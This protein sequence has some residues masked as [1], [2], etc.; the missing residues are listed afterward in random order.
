MAVS[1]DERVVEM[2]FNNKQFEEGVRQS[3][4]SLDN[5]DQSIDNLD[6]KSLNNL[7]ERLNK[8]NFDAL[9]RGMDSLEKRFSAFGV[10]GMT[11]IQDLVHG[12]EGLGAKLLSV[13]TKPLNIMKEGGWARA[14]NIE[15]AKFQIE[16]LGLSFEQLESSI[17]KA[18][19]GT[20]YGF[21]A[22]AKAAGQ[23]SAS[24]VKAGKD[25]DDAL[26]AI[27]GVAA[28]T[29]KSYEEISPIF[30]AVAGQ[31]KA[32]AMQMNQL[33]LKGVNAYSTLAKYLGKT[34]AQVRE[35][36]SDGKV[37]FKIFA[38]AMND[39]FGEHATKA[40]ETYEGSLANMQARLKQIGQIVATEW[41]HGMIGVHNAVR[42]LLTV[43]KE[44]L[45]PILQN[46]VNPVIH[47]V[48]AVATAVINKIGQ[49]DKFRDVIR[50]IG[51]GIAKVAKAVQKLF[52]RAL[53]R[54]DPII[55]DL[56]D[57]GKAIQII[58]KNIT[59]SEKELRPTVVL[60]KALDF[61][62]NGILTII[63][64]I[65]TG[66]KL[67]TLTLADSGIGEVIK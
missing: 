37:N 49:S 56:Y 47:D 40:N 27:S 19:D 13:V 24:G 64:G 36:V 65:V 11:V 15:N 60:I 33:A 25:M 29:N 48:L 14:M 5:L 12:I 66:I 52:F 35:M 38:E 62:L 51:N 43:V 28:M 55:N 58:Y 31:G 57:I 26:R 4:K 22:A 45:V 44:E 63:Q 10:A 1:I 7:V 39:A 54:L 50:N 23:L 30:T 9:E 53:L 41:I 32:M 17:S 6:N 18:V 8:I 20:A 34:E 59:G 2:R 42:N 21:D 46:K 67:I 3:M 61:V 16:G